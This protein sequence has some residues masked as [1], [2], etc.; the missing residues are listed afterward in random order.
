MAASDMAEVVIPDSIADFFES[1]VLPFEQM[2]SPIAHKG[3]CVRR[4]DVGT[5]RRW[6]GKS[7]RIVKPPETSSTIFRRETCVCRIKES[8]AGV[9]STANIEGGR[10]VDVT[11]FEGAL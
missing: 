9:D 8:A 5:D 7:G 6:F 11:E 10:A 1:N 4:N 2:Q 3:S